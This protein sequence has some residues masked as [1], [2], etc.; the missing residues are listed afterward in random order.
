MY[1]NVLQLALQ[2]RWTCGPPLS[3]AKDILQ[4]G[5]SAVK[6]HYLGYMPQLKKLPG[7]T[8][9]PWQRGVPPV[10]QSCRPL[11]H[12][13][14]IHFCIWGGC[15]LCL[16]QHISPWY[17]CRV[18]F[19]LVP[20]KLGLFPI[21]IRIKS[22]LEKIV[23]TLS[24]TLGQKMSH[25]WKCYGRHISNQHIPTKQPLVTWQDHTLCQSPVAWKNS[26]KSVLESMFSR[27]IH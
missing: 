19:I 15:V 23:V 25:M 12:H 21:H 13:A 10:T 3:E 1:C 20:T 4:A 5:F 7:A 9:S 24:I 6:C 17:L 11:W 14:G 2:P 22:N 8:P 26:W 27:L 18:E 16:L